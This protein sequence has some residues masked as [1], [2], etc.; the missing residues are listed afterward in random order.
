MYIYFV[1]EKIKNKKYFLK[2]EH[3]VQ[4]SKIIDNKFNYCVTYI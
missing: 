3:K 1:W 2:N 4:I